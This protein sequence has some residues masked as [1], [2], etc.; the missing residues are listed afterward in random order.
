M[1]GK[2]VMIEWEAGVLVWDGIVS[3]PYTKLVLSEFR[4]ER[5]KK[6]HLLF[7]IASRMTGNL[8]SEV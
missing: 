6:E 7:G 1:F 5:F 4:K 8:V 2:S 3:G